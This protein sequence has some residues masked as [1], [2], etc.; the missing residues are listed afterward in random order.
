MA[1]NENCNHNQKVNFPA[2]R[3]RIEKSGFDKFCGMCAL[4]PNAQ[5]GS[6]G[7]LW[8]CLSCGSQLCDQDMKLHALLHHG[9]PRADVHALA[10]NTDTFD[11]EFPFVLDITQYCAPNVLQEQ[12]RILYALYGLTVLSSGKMTAYVKVR[13]PIGTDD[14]RWKFLSQH[15]KDDLQ[16]L[17]DRAADLMSSPLC[18]ENNEEIAQKPAEHDASEQEDPEMQPPPGKWYYVLDTNFFEVPD[19]AVLKVQPISVF[20]ERIA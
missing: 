14:V 20:Y 5:K 4:D 17:A 10:M 1:T 8:L 9:V 15:S 6:A 3:N 19:E 12:K 13:Q 16:I 2:V 11:T 18:T 7:V